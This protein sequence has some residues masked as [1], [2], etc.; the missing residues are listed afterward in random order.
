MIETFGRDMTGEVCWEA[1]REEP[2]PCSLCTNAQLIDEKGLPSW[3]CVWQDRNPITGKFY[4]NHDRA[5]EWI[6]GR[7]VRLQIATDITQF[8]RME[9]QLRQAQ[10]MESIG[11]LAGGIAHD[12][13][14]IL[15]PIVGHTEM[16]LS[17]ISK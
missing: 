8:K 6:D 5:I 9:E 16:L 13:N 15:F 11:T 14:N 17:D 1:F 10:K 7:I 12:F 4:I 3:V 2:G